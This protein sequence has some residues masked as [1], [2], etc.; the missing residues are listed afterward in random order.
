MT[1][2]A[3]NLINELRYKTR[4][5]RECGL[6][7]QSV[8]SELDPNRRLGESLGTQPRYEASSDL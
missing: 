7:I 1:T 8:A 4:D 6:V 2:I 3:E 5:R